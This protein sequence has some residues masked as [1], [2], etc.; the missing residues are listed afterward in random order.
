[1]RGLIRTAIFVFTAA[2]TPGMGAPF[3]PE[4]DSQALEHLP[5]T[6]N[7]PVMGELRALRDQLKDQ[8]DNLP[9]AVRLARGY[10]ELGR[11]TGDPRY[12]GYAQAAL[13]PWWD[14]KQPPEQIRFCGRPCA[15]ASINSTPPL[16][17]WEPC[18]PP[19]L[20]MLRRGSRGRQCCKCK[21]P[22]TPREMNVW[23][24]RI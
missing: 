4:S 2:V 10:L 1:L 23:L 16:R 22:S 12:A 19:I 7:D 17:I 14:L 11:V 3:I 20:A 5:F 24:S 21:A 18:S 15:N 9:L 13:N 6:A 8:P